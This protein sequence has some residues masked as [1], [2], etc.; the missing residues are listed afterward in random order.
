MV[1]SLSPLLPSLA[2]KR[3]ALGDDDGFLGLPHP[4]LTASSPK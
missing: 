4:A 3:K 1:R 2:P